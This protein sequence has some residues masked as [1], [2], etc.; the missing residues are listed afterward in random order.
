MKNS[1]IKSSVLGVKIDLIKLNNLLDRFKAYLAQKKSHIV[2]TVN[3]EFIVTAQ[4]DPD[5]KD[6]LNSKSSLNIA[7]GIGPIWAMKFLSFKEINLP[8]IRPIAILLEWFLSIVLI[9][10]Y[11]SFFKNPESERISGANLIWDIAK[12]A[13]KDNYKIFLLGGAPTIAERT[14]L[15]LQTEIYGLKIAGVN[16]GNPEKETA[17]MINS[18]NKS[19]TDILLVAFGHAKQEKWLDAN[20]PKTTARLG[21]GL[22]GAFDFVAGK[23]KRAP[24]FIQK[25]GLE[26]FYRL[27]QDP[28][29]IKRQLAIPYF[30]WLVLLEKLK[31]KAVV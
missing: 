24:K 14:A 8:I 1:P 17:E 16:S 26:W 25:I 20:L 2:C 4:H 15:K 21:I 9:P 31:N 19:K 13:K 23:R 28:R 29:R 5:F 22:G 6:I 3:A 30:M 11:P 7:D 18:I 10:I 27:V 12:M